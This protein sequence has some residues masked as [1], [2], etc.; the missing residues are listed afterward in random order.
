MIHAQNDVDFIEAWDWLCRAV[1]QAVPDNEMT[2]SAHHYRFK[3]VEALNLPKTLRVSCDTKLTISLGKEHTCWRNLFRSCTLVSTS[4]E[5]RTRFGKGLEMPFDIL[6]SMAA[7]EFQLIVENGIVFV[8]YHTIHYPTAIDWNCA[9]FH[10]LTNEEGQIN[11]YLQ[12]YGSRILTGDANQFKRKRCFLGW[13]ADAQINLGT[14][15]LPTSVGYT[16]G[17][18]KHTSLVKTGYAALAQTGASAPLSAVLGLQTNYTYCS[19]KLRFDPTSNYHRLLTN[20]AR[21]VALIYDSSERRA[22]LVPKLGLLLHM[23]LAYT[24]YCGCPNDRVPLV[25][26]YTDGLALTKLLNGM[27]KNP[28]LGDGNTAFQFQQLLLGLNINLLRAKDAGK[29][30]VDGKL[31]GFE[32]KDIIMQPGA[33]SCMKK[34]DLDS[35]SKAWISLA[36]EVDALLVCSGLGDAITA[37][38][39]GRVKNGQCHKMPQSHDYLGPQYH[40]SENWSAAE[41]KCWVTALMDN[42]SE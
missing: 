30:S 37:A 18:Y 36:N 14:N 38:D 24:A 28:V 2:L 31:Y 17:K 6:L 27:G 33:G 3:V 29:P 13:C 34:L 16:K 41:E 32:F 12:V 10:L 21:E 4:L 5:Q 35:S 22:W 9:Q 11:P 42:L 25:E 7:V 40:V 19:H 8:G 20:A 1:Y 23:S 15:K 26:P 39:D